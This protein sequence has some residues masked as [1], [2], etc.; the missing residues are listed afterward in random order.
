MLKY[1]YHIVGL[2]N[3]VFNVEFKMTPTGPKLIEINARMG[4][5]Y[6]RDWIKRIYG[7]DLMFCAMQISCGIKPFIPKM[8]PECQMMGVMLV[9]SLHGQFLKKS[10]KSSN[11]IKRMILNDEIV[12]NQFDNEVNAHNHG[13]HE[14]PV[15]NVAVAAENVEMAKEKLLHICSKLKIS[16]NDYQ[17]DYF[18]KDF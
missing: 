3:G 4:G 12:W 17:V 6:L 2:G 16:S 1:K 9:P 15:A 10:S 14:E 5:F 18:T 8:T 13:D 11:E 7:V